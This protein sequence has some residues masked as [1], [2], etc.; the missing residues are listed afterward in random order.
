MDGAPPPH[1]PPAL[2]AWQGSRQQAARSLPLERIALPWPSRVRAPRLASLALDCPGMAPGA[3]SMPVLQGL[4]DEAFHA[5]TGARPQA[6]MQDSLE[7]M[8]AG[9][10]VGAG[11]RSATRPLD[12]L[13]WRQPYGAW[14]D[15]SSAGIP[16][17]P[18]RGRG[19]GAAPH[20]LLALF[21][22]RR[23]ETGKRAII[24]PMME[25]PCRPPP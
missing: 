20:A 9:Q 24:N 11:A 2:A 19:D 4:G 8:A 7:P 5:P 15:G 23:G 1:H 17:A 16:P 22:P 10:G 21:L 6:L 13:T 18:R 3:R 12:G 14:R 25:R